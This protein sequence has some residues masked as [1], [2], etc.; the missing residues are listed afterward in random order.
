M[1]RHLKPGSFRHLH[2]YKLLETSLFDDKTR[3]VSVDVFDTLLLRDT[4]SEVTRFNNIAQLWS[5][6]LGKSFLGSSEH[7]FQL[8]LESARLAYRHTRKV[9][10]CREATYSEILSSVLRG[11]SVPESYSRQLQY[12]EIEYEKKSLKP[13]RLLVKMLEQ[14]RTSEK[15]V[16]AISDMYFSS[17]IIKTLIDHHLP[18]GLIQ[19]VY[20]SSD[21]GYGK[22]SGFL[23]ESVRKAEK[24]KNYD[25]WT[26]G[27]DNYY[28]DV[29]KAKELGINAFYLPRSIAWR[30]VSKTRRTASS[31]R[32][33]VNKL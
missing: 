1:I 7:L 21:F 12:S 17:E 22:S 14:V 19:K 28:A 2:N 23:Y 6:E 8:R 30:A 33:G 13:N 9:K 15:R 16:I 10:N 29:L 32:L 27:G 5:N 31:F 24:I 18:S 3:I 4:K 20:S 25:Q 26:H 11:C